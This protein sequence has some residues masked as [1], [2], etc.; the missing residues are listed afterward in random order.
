MNARP[1]AS[2]TWLAASLTAIPWL[3]PFTFGPMS[4]AVPWIVSFACTLALWLLARRSTPQVHWGIAAAA[5]LGVLWTAVVHHVGSEAFYLGAGL[6][7]MVIATALPSSPAA[8][9][10]IQRGLLIAASL[11]ALIGLSQYFGIAPHLQPWVFAGNAGEAYG[12]LRQPNQYVSL[13]WMGIALLLFGRPKLSQNASLCLAVLLAVAAAASTSRTGLLQALLVFALALAWP[14][15]ARRQR[16]MLS[17]AALAAYF[18][19]AAL[20]PLLLQSVT[21]ELPARTLW[22]RF[23]AGDSCSSRAVLWS[24]VLHLIAQ[25]P[26]IGWGWGELDYAHFAT[27]YPDERFCDILDNAHNLPLHL[28]VELGVPA[29]V[30]ISALALGW[31]IR[32]RPWAEQNPQRQCAWSLLLLLLL[33]SL[34]EYPLWYGPFQL[35]L[36]AS[37]GWLR[38]DESTPS[39]PRFPRL[40]TA[41]ASLLLVTTAYASSDYVRVSQAYLQPEQRFSRWREAP[42]SQAGGSWLFANQV[43]FAELTTTELTR[44][45]ANWMHQTSKLMLHHSPEPRV[46]ERAVESASLVGN[47]SEA[48]LQLA[49]FRAAFPREY[50][51]WRKSAALPRQD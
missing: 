13:C 18:C 34:L 46:I 36:G 43:T 49:R 10:G 14:G 27:L 1:A 39:V 17:V 35:V 7:L 38:V 29:A 45:N 44:A 5:S 24:N 9:N 26:L 41:L 37:I 12:N 19:A 20:L 8:A 23:G 51:A 40:S 30:L 50:E 4:G 3:N 22:N 31:L 32:Q 25:K 47:E 2:N 21:G 48:L 42:L 28:A 16:F 15:D 6:L 11:N 33:H